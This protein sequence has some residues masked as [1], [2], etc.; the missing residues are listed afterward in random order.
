VATT[1]LPATNNSNIKLRFVFDSDEGLSKDG[2][3]I[4]DIHIY[5]NIYGIYENTGASPVVNV[6]GVSGSNWVDFV[7]SGT[8]RLIVSI[9]PNGQTPGNTDA[10][11]FVHTGPVRINSDQYYHNRN[12]TVKPGTVNLAD[13]VTVRFYFL[14]TETE[15]LL[16]ATGCSY[17]HKPSTAYDLGVTKYSDPDDTKENGTIADNTPGLYVYMNPDQVTI[18]PFDKGY[19]AEFKVRDFSEFWLNN[20]GFDHNQPLP[21]EL[22]SFTANRKGN[23]DVLVEWVTASEPGVDR[24]EIE[25]AKGSL[26]LQQQGFI[27]IGER[28]AAGNP[29]MDEHYQFTDTEIP[30]SGVR[31]YRLKTVDHDGSI[32]YSAIRPVIFQEEIKWQ[33]SPNPSPG[34]FVLSLQAEAGVPVDIRVVD[35]G[36]RIVYQSTV[37]ATGFIQRLSI[38]LQAERHSAGLY[39]LEA[40]AAESRQTFRL[41]KQ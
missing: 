14:D 23:T 37:K 9:N 39:L 35:A 24:F 33:V 38:D 12:I 13:S 20:G 26:A 29:G 30:K 10:Q 2:M 16:N 22:L 3:A 8:N 32:S 19:Y 34:I 41:L 6:S 28:P 5:D 18:V 27:K 1:A 17:C 11:S 15:A 31:Y 25:V 4:D 7:E 40:R 21:V 36:G